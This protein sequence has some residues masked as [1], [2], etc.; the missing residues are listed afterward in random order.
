M[1]SLQ[2][3]SGLNDNFCDKFRQ[4]TQK[5]RE[6]ALL[7]ATVGRPECQQKIEIEHDFF[8]WRVAIN[9]MWG[10]HEKTFMK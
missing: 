4:T 6:L 3:F 5:A 9:T 8:I 2:R 10:I 7:S 1:M